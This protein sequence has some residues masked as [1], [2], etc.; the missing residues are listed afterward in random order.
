MSQEN[1]TKSIAM[2]SESIE[3]KSEAA[4]TK[5]N[6]DS[7]EPEQEK[8]EVSS[9]SEND[10]SDSGLQVNSSQSQSLSVGDDSYQPTTDDNL[11]SPQSTTTQSSEGLSAQASSNEVD[12]MVT[13]HPSET[14]KTENV[15]SAPVAPAEEQESSVLGDFVM[16]SICRLQRNNTILPTVSNL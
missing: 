1:E 12:K 4:V 15:E 8:H 14:E 5:S 16:Q 3:A 10:S 6:A 11:S 2:E 7:T 9:V 13:N